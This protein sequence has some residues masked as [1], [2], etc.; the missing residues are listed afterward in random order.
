MNVSMTASPPT[1]TPW[2][3]DIAHWIDKLSHSMPD[4]IGITE[5]LG[6]L[7]H[8]RLKKISLLKML[9]DPRAL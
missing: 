1:S 2:D 6:F 7:L 5:S 9:P 8:F 4:L 3:E